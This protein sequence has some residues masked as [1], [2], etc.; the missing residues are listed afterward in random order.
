MLRQLLL[1]ERNRPHAHLVVAGVGIFVVSSRI[2]ERADVLDQLRRRPGFA[3]HQKRSHLQRLSGRGV[4]LVARHPPPCGLRVVHNRGRDVVFRTEIERCEA[5]GRIVGS[6]IGTR[7]RHP[8][9][10]LI[11]ISVFVPRHHELV[12][13]VGLAEGEGANPSIGAER[14]GPEFDRNGASVVRQDVLAQLDVPGRALGTARE[15]NGRGVRDDCLAGVGGVDDPGVFAAARL[16]RQIAVVERPA[17]DE[18]RRATRAGGERAALHHH[19]ERIGGER[20]LQTAGTSL[21][22]C[23]GRAERRVGSEP[24]ARGQLRFGERLLPNAHL[25][26]G[27]GG[28]VV[29]V[30]G[31]PE[32]AV[33]LGRGGERPTR[34]RRID[35]GSEQR[36]RHGV[37]LVDGN[38]PRAPRR[39]RRREHPRDVVLDAERVRP[40][41]GN[42]V[43]LALV[44][45]GLVGDADAV[46]IDLRFRTPRH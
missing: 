34:W 36:A 23:A 11:E 2:T 38:R 30:Q 19:V 42:V 31:V 37:V 6:A 14:R 16:V 26:K 9:E 22:D 1:G 13:V 32:P 27:R 17:V 7:H 10:V 25:V 21:D 35:M 3:V 41:L 33:V 15:G 5:V 40:G 45:A 43:E 20:Q 24:H 18:R 46:L 28:V 44:T 12:A 29:V 8:Q 39:S 4:L